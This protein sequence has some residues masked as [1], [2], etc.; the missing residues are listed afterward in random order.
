VPFLASMIGVMDVAGFFLVGFILL[1]AVA[2]ITNTMMMSTFER[3]HEFGM[4]L[5]LGCSPR[6]IV[7]LIFVEAIVLGVLGVIVG[8]ALGLLTVS[9]MA[10]AGV[11]VMGITAEGGG[12]VAMSGMNFPGLIFP[13]NEVTDVLVGA[14]A[15]LL[16]SML[17]AIWPA[18]YAAG[19]EPMDAMR[20]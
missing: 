15:V 13:R 7:R 6:R 4:L 18:S 2:G 5:G 3:L 20:A 8:T 14:I 9:S 11:D 16:T 19:L 1:A 17:A 12:D 10:S